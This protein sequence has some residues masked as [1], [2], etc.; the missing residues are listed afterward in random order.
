MSLSAANVHLVAAAS[1][2]GEPLRTVQLLPIGDI[3]ARDGRRWHVVDQAHAE[4]IVD[5]SLAS[6]GQAELAFDY[7]HQV[8]FAAKPGVG[9]TA[10]ASGWIKRLY[11]TAQGVF[12]DVEWTPAAE[13]ALRAKEYRYVSPYFAHQADGRIT[14]I[15]NAALTNTPAITDLPAVASADLSTDQ[16]QS[17]KFTQQLAQALGLAE[18]AS[19]ADILA[20]VQARASAASAALD[21]VAK[22]LGLQ[23]GAKPDEVLSA[24]TAAASAK[25]NP[26]EFVPM[27]AFQELQTKVAELTSTAAASAAQT[28][29]DEAVAA[30]KLTP[31]LKD[32]GLD[33][34]STN[35]EGFKTWVASAPQV[36]KP[37]ANG[38]RQPTPPAAGAPTLTPEL[39]A[40]AAALG[41]SHEDILATA[42]EEAN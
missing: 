18:A 12:A 31:S 32:W 16:E 3:R 14:R 13:A 19:E 21:P 6:A 4:A 36:V 40:A 35:P 20:A 41:L 37:A 8:P 42:K 2:S 5:A 17:V 24:A 15:L 27:S 22:A 34:A 28:A 1:D 30:G 9:G 38:A 11:A 26:A 29:V 33:Y 25:P 39:E 7:D 23:A 10:K